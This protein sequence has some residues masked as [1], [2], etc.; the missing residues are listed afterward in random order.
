MEGDRRV[1]LMEPAA[2]KNVGGQ[3]RQGAPVEHVV[4]ALR[5]DRGGGEGV[6]ADTR[7]GE[8]QTRFEVRA[9]GLAALDHTWWLIDERGRKYDIEAVAEAPAGRGRRLYLYAVARS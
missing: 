7:V 6:Q 1:V 4:W 9:L 3:L 5:R 2:G 8:W